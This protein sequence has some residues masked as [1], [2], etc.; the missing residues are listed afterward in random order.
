ME[1]T[2][3][4]G[5]LTFR[6]IALGALLMPLLVAWNYHIEVVFYC[7]ATYAAPFFNVVCFLFALTLLNTLVARLVPR[8]ALRP[9]ELIV[10]YVMLSVQ[11]ALCSHN[12]MEILITML[13]HP[14]KFARPENRWDQLFLQRLP[15]WLF[16]KDPRVFDDYY[17]GNSSFW[18]AEH[19]RGWARPAFWW[20][21]FLT[22][23]LLTMLCF[24]QLLRKRW[25]EH[26][27][28]S[29]PVLQLPLALVQRPRELY[30][31][32]MF[33]AGF[34][35]AGLLSLVAGLHELY[36]AVPTVPTG[37]HGMAAWFPAPPFNVL[38][39][40]RWAIYPW[41]IGIAFLMPI[42]LAFSSFLFYVIFCAERVLGAK[43]GWSSAGGYPW[44][45]DRAFGAYVG[46]LFMGLWV[47]RD[48]FSAIV[49]QAVTVW[50]RPM[51]TEDR[52][53]RIAFWGA[54][55][56]VAWLT[57]FAAQLGMTGLVALAFFLVYF[58]LAIMITRI[59]AEMGFP[60][61]DMH[62]MSPP[63]TFTRLFTPQ[64]FGAPNLVGFTCLWWFNRTYASH[65]MP[66]LLEGYKMVSETHSD[67]R[68]LT[69]GIIVA[70]ILAP[71]FVFLIVPHFYYHYGSATGNVNTWGTQFG[72][73]AFGQLEA[74]LKAPK[75]ADASHLWATGAG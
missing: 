68:R 10:V 13:P 52:G 31:Q 9:G 35:T 4:R 50:R 33:W 30:G 20:S 51:D 36:P 64:T 41:A 14:W 72:S 19:L 12:M 40:M 55:A 8:W 23:L 25:I 65:P 49:R 54:I 21:T 60:T 74:W 45:T 32:R 3:G 17:L 29:Y 34:A 42:D 57:W 2:E 18:T 11:G 75:R 38:Q 26:E 46:L 70:A 27:R 5:W 15:D 16:I 22:V 63:H 53:Y 39:G 48:H 67:N 7:F 73:Q 66:H 71:W 62:E 61:H 43:M 59:R 1:R 56:G 37:R 28:L 24:T 69:A 58:A 47:G 6:A 44:P